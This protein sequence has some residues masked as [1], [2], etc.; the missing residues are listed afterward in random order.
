MA[1]WAEHEIVGL[2][3]DSA[4]TKADAAPASR[5]FRA[6]VGSA[7]GWGLVGLESIGNCDRECRNGF[8]GALAK[9]PGGG[10]E[11]RLCAA[12]AGRTQ[13]A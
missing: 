1:D 3:C 11:S 2:M 8:D 10:P 5:R 9:N 7:R 12:D 6:K 4:E 13:D